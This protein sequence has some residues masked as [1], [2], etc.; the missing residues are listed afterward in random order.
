MCKTA[1]GGIFM[2]NLLTVVKK[3]SLVAACLSLVLGVMGVCGVTAKASAPVI[4]QTIYTN[5]Q[6]TEVTLVVKV[7]KEYFEKY[8]VTLICKNPNTESGTKE[9]TVPDYVGFDDGNSASW[10]FSND[11]NCYVVTFYIKRATIPVGAKAYFESGSAVADN[12]GH[13]YFLFE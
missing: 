2:K 4:M 11:E 12:G 13:G 1:K 10:Y 8:G 3:I 5:D 9:F 7:A 6:K